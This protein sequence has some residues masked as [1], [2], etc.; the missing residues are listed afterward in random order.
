MKPEI[1]NDL[2]IRA[3]LKGLFPPAQGCEPASDPGIPRRSHLNPNGVV[4][5]LQAKPAL[6]VSKLGSC[7]TA[8][9][10]RNKKPHRGTAE[11]AEYAE[12]A[13][14]WNKFSAYSAYSAVKSF[15]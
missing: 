4:V 10:G 14:G 2:A 12:R 9:T 5:A 15:F 13:A 7:T 6:P 8:R 11:Y 3:I 1:R